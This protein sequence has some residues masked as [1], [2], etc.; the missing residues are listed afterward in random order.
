MWQ[1]NGRLPGTAGSIVVQALEAK[2]DTFPDDPGTTSRAARNVDALWAMSLDSLAGGDG[3]TI[4][5]S[6][7][8]LTVFVDATDAAAT[9]GQA[10]VRPR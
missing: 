3:A 5:T 2:T 10:G 6:T 4:E 1:L 7:P 9:R 8:L